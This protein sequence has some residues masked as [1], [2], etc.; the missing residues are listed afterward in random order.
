MAHDKTRLIWRNRT[1]SWV[2]PVVAALIAVAEAKPVSAC[3]CATPDSPC[4]AME[5]GA[6]IFVGTPVS[7]EPTSFRDRTVAIRPFADVRTTETRPAVRLHFRVDEWIQASLDA[8][9]AKI[10]SVSTDASGA[11]CGYHFEMGTSYLVYAYQSDDGLVVSLCSRTGP[12]VAREQDL[13][14][15][16]ETKNGTVRTRL[17]GGVYRM[18]LFVDGS[19]GHLEVV[20]GVSNVK[21]TTESTS[22]RQELR[23]N[24]DGEFTF[25]GLEPGSYQVTPSLPRG[26]K[27]LFGLKNPVTL[28]SCSTELGIA[29]AATPLSGIV[30]NADGSPVGPAVRVDVVSADDEARG[31]SQNRSTFTFTESDGTWEFEGLPPGRYRVGVN[32]FGPPTLASPYRPTWYPKSARAAE[33]LVLEIS[34]NSNTRV[35]LQTPAPIPERSIDGVVLDASGVPVAEATVSLFDADRTIGAVAHAR[36]GPDGR[37]TIRA[38]QGRQYRVQAS[39]ASGS[40]VLSATQDVP[41]VD[42]SEPLRLVVERTTR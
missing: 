34:D 17:F 24:E 38:L 16:H 6:V 3:S 8:L 15:L 36:S 12:V 33:A 42:S 5:S 23:T 7:A 27:I 25:V 40:F 22:S 14:L 32:L 19:F 10:V 37:F 30:R 35:E 9:A 31:L 18:E 11:S 20:A 39:S 29:I 28:D 21:I 41:R 2:V 26:F 1:H 4:A 13:A